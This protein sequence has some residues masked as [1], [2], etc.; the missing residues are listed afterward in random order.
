MNGIFR[1]RLILDFIEVGLIV[2]C[3]VTQ[4]TSTA[5]GNPSALG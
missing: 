2:A 1:V 5:F 4:L 3:L